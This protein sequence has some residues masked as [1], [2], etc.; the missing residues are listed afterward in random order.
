MLLNYKINMAFTFIIHEKTGKRT[1]RTIEEITSADTDGKIWLGC[2][3]NRD[4]GLCFNTGARF[5]TKT[6]NFLEDVKYYRIRDY[7][8]V[9]DPKCAL[10]VDFYN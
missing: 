5:C 7:G 2:A 6:K 4:L 1:E 9:L 3:S 10:K 8:K